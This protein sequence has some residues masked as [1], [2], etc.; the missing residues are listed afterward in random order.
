MTTTPTPYPQP[1]ATA[2]APAAPAEKAPRA[3]LEARRK[4]LDEE[5]AALAA[6]ELEEAKPDGGSEDEHIATLF[7]GL[8]I[9]A[10]DN[11]MAHVRNFLDAIRHKHH[12]EPAEPADKPAE[13][14]PLP[15]EPFGTVVAPPPAPTG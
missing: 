2:P 14:S 6:A 12:D 13:P 7:S 9:Q 15:T 3:D 11:E 8:R 5:E 1:F 10:G 4:K